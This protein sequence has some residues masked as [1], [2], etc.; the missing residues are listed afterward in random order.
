MNSNFK[1]ELSKLIA[2]DV[3]SV[4]IAEKIDNYYNSKQEPQ[5][6]KLL[7]I[8]GVIGSLLVGL[9]IILVLAH[10]W[11]NFSKLTKTIF[12][13]IPLVI[14]QI[15]VGYSLLKKKSS[16]WLESSGTF[17]FLAVGSSIS[18]IS[19]IY[20]IPGNL[21]SF[22]L[23]WLILC[24]PLVYLLKSKSVFI[25]CL[26]FATYYACELGYA[27]WNNIK[28]PWMYLL[29]IIAL[30]PF[31]ITQLKYKLEHNLSTVFNFL[32]PLS[33]LISFGTFVK[34]NY[35]FI[36]ITYVIFFGFLY[37]LGKLNFFNTL[38]I[39]RNGF[40]LL[41]SLGLLVT[42][43]VL[44]FKGF[45]NGRLLFQKINNHDLIVAIVILMATIGLLFYNKKASIFKWNSLFEYASLLIA[46][47]YVVG[48]FNNLISS[49]LVNLIIFIL[50]VSTI[51]K[52][53]DKMNFGI[54]NYGMLIITLLIICRFFDTEMTFVVR[55]LLF[56]LVGIGFFAT[57]FLMV[58]KMKKL[59]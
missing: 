4:E 53:A 2:D 23:T 3:I 27:N 33:L 40:I 32:L 55:G 31:Y 41:G 26:V 52:G 51:K 29:V 15:A 10:N 47:T 7:S 57:N 12:A 28:T 19:Q 37:N 43:L 18:L 39:R 14:G 34:G 1:K 5:S 22:L 44:S 35:Q 46:M 38:R 58:K 13:F 9:G 8:F 42:M 20:N 49:T 56:I 6:N 54:L 59:N 30:L 21:G 25:L 11:D 36:V 17:L 24:L 50:G 16:T 48:N 45:W